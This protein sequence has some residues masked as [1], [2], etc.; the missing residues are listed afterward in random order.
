[1][2]QTLVDLAAYRS[3]MRQRFSMN[4][5]R[6][7]MMIAREWVA[8]HPDPSTA[9]YR[10]VE[11]WMRDRALSASSTRNM[12]VCLRALYRWLIREGLVLSD[13]TVLVD[14]PRV[15]RRMPRPADD[16]ELARLLRS[17]DPQLRALYALMGFA[18]LRCVECS[19]LDWRDVDLAGGWLI[20]DGKGRI[21]RR[22]PLCDDVVRTLIALRIASPHRNG[23]V[24]VGPH[25]GRLEPWRV[26]QLVNESIRAS[27]S[28][29]TAHQLR[30]RY[31]TNLAQRP[32]VDLLAV[33]DLL[34]H[35]SIATTQIYTQ[36]AGGRAEEL[37]RSMKFP[38]A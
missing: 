4:T 5:V 31:A 3:Y 22:Q 36:G 11:R 14:R 16:I 30:H 33:R 37:A 15:P 13:P 23:A 6:P 20:A 28:P 18:G 12:I 8:R 7:R 2:A 21:E 35:A 29:T 10:D 26:S 38:A 19:R 9:T 17:P 24:F 27:G 25:G 32:G 34:G 1:M